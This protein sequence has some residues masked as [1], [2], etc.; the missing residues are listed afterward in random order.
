M[1]ADSPAGFSRTGCAGDFA[2]ASVWVMNFALAVAC[3]CVC[4][5]AVCVFVL[6]FQ[7]EHS[8]TTLF[9]TKPM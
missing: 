3:A 2:P 7:W 1:R 8:I 5:S 6:R 4:A 9:T